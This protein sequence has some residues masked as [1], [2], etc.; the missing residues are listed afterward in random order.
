MQNK[1]LNMKYLVSVVVP[2]KNRYQ[3]L[4]YLIKLIDSFNL[5]ELEFVIQDNSDNNSEIIMWL[6][7]YKKTNIKYYYSSEELTMSQNAELAIKHAEGE[8]VCFIGDDDGVCR[9]IVECVKWMKRNRISAAYNNNTI[10]TWGGKA[11]IVKP[12]TGIEWYD[13]KEELNKLLSHGFILSDAKMPLL[14]HGIV[15]KEVLEKIGEKYCTIFPSVPPDISG[16]ICL[17]SV[18]DC[19]CVFRVPVIINGSSKM[20]AGG[21]Y[22]KGGRVQLKDVGFISSKEIEE[23]EKGLPPLWYTSTAYA[24]AGIKTLRH[25][26]MSRLISKYDI[27]YGLAS[28]V[29]LFPKEM[30][31][32]R[33]GLKYS[34]SS[35]RFMI[36]C[37][38]KFFVRCLKKVWKMIPL[39]VVERKNVFSIIE[40]ESF[41]TN[42]SCAFEKGDFK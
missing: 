5:P 6:E 26:G 40:A 23:W 10:F 11:R 42:Y 35:I 38:Y 30:T 17:A 28:E 22:S 18:I 7:H 9:N 3:Y 27:D 39:T 20:T 36:I 14:Y 41:F 15:S 2:T 4:K 37:F 34:K 16:S 32:W 19:V 21:V 8:Y 24:N 13:S 29:S 31:L 1:I 25:I 33:M 12:L